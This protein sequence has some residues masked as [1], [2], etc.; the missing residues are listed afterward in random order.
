MKY[1]LLAVLGLSST[2]AQAEGVGASVKGGTLGLGA[3]VSTQLSEQLTA[4]IGFNAYDYKF[5]DTQSSVD[6]EFNLQLQTISAL[7][8]WYPWSGTFRVSAGL[9]YN[10]NEATLH[11]VPGAGATYTI[12]G[13]SYAANS[14]VESLDGTLT[15]KPI[16]PYFGIGWGNPAA[17]EKKWGFVADV[18]ALYQRSPET[19]LRVT[20]ASGFAGCAALQ[21][22]AAAEQV[23]L[24]SLRKQL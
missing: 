20:C 17:K 3:E 22:D 1:I 7:A 13:V 6:Y 11:G 16:A 14:A 23:K 10:N 8:D 19:S 18:G 12:N 21:A 24:Q 5:T 15:F 4:R 9:M 2:L